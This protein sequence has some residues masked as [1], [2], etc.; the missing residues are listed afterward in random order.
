MSIQI[1]AIAYPNI[2]GRCVE[3]HCRLPSGAILKAKGILPGG[4]DAEESYEMEFASETFGEYRA[5]SFV[6]SEHS[7]QA[8]A[9]SLW[10]AGIR[11]EASKSSQ[12]Q[13]EAQRAHLED[14]RALAF[15]SLK[16]KQP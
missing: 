7:A 16:V 15:Q 1:E 4:P 6:M 11:P 12:G 3:L 13:F 5:P 2:A 8:L 14:M 9:N 10:H